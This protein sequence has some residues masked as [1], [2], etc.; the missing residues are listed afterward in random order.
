M[1]QRRSKGPSG[2]VQEHSAAHLVEAWPAAGH[3]CAGPVNAPHWLEQGWAVGGPGPRRQVA[4]VA[5]PNP[6]LGRPQN[7]RGSLDAHLCAC[8]LTCME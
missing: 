1:Q 5:A 4:G 2:R 3:L 7:L 6:L 8:M